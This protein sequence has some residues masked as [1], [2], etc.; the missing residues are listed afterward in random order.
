MSQDSASAVVPDALP[1]ATEVTCLLVEDQ[2]MFRELLEGMLAIRGGLRIVGRAETVAAGIA[3]CTFHA[4]DVLLL[5]LALPDGD[6]LDVARRF[7]ECNPSG[8]VIIVTGHAGSFVCPPWLDQRL[9]AVIS[10]NE[11]F[12][13]LRAE[14]DEM[15]PPARAMSEDAAPRAAGKSLTKR[16][17]EVFR[18]VGEGFS[19][20]EIASRLGVSV[21]TVL[22]H[23]KRLAKKL[24]TR[25]LELTK[26]AVAQRVAFF[27]SGGERP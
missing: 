5:D 22:T 24:G 12:Q 23:R 2:V 3:E 13:S 4:A 16:E 8:R 25:G 21:H 6:G 17:A 9:Q 1:R 11:T 27:T 20:H 19:S 10:K 15:L 14:L 7:V 18:L 26:R